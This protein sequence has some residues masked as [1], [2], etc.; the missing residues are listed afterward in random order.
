[1]LSPQCK[2]RLRGP[3]RAD[4]EATSLPAYHGPSWV[5]QE[6]EGSGNCIPPNCSWLCP[7]ALLPSLP[8]ISLWPSLNHHWPA[9]LG[10]AKAQ[11]EIGTN[12][13]P[14][15]LSLLWGLTDSYGHCS[16]DSSNWQATSKLWTHA[17][18]TGRRSV[19]PASWKEES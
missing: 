17:R 16:G 15:T 10:P 18:H 2:D 13:D 6:K 4:G 1:M 12:E 9:C 19:C 14:P 7:S 11:V 3:C 8:Q 5:G